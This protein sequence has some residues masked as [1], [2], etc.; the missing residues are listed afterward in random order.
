MFA[1]DSLEQLHFKKVALKRFNCE[2]KAQSIK[3]EFEYK[4]ALT[5]IDELMDAR[6]QTPEGAELEAL[7]AVVYEYEEKH[8][9]IGRVPNRS[10]RSR[11]SET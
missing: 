8:Y 5:R 11:R 7:A 9:P 6:A 4:K 10:A 2:M 1:L 3:T